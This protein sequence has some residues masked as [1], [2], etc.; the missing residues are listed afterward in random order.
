MVRLSLVL[1]PR[2]LFM[3][4]KERETSHAETWGIPRLLVLSEECPNC[5][6]IWT[7]TRSQL[8]TEPGLELVLFRGVDCCELSAEGI[9]QTCWNQVQ[10]CLQTRLCSPW[11]HQCYSGG[12]LAHTHTC[13]S[14]LWLHTQW[15]AP[16]VFCLWLL[17][18]RFHQQQQQRLQHV[19]KKI[20]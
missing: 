12:L 19:S 7:F 17:R 10:P 8:L 15:R 1:D 18:L 6:V 11:Q 9:R 20:K 4:V 5:V 14:C 2:R 3:L 13:S 16:P